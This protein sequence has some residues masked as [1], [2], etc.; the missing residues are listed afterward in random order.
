MF[1]WLK[2]LYNSMLVHGFVRESF[3]DN[4]I[5]P[6][7]KYRNA[8]Y[9]DPTNCRPI[10]I[11]PICT[12]LFEQCFVPVF[13]LFLSFHSNQFGF[14]PDGCNKAL[15]AFRTTVEY[16]QNN[17]SR[18]YVASLDFSKAFNRVNHYG[19]LTLLMK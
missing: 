9:N 1:I 3:G 7:V 5:I 4:D 6:I 8:N 13:E 18:V 15:F 2:E 10:F 19:L 16:F 11:E 17:N 14:V 12:K